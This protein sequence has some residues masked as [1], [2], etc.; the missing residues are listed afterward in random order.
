MENMVINMNKE[1]EM[2]QAEM[3]ASKDKIQQLEAKKNA[4]V[5]QVNEISVH[6]IT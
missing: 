3:R 6:A 4:L 2:F 1:R 5:E